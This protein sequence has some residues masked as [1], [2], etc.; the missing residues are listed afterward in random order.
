MATSIKRLIQSEQQHMLLLFLPL[1]DN[2]AD[3]VQHALTTLKQATAPVNDIRASTGVHFSMFYHLP[4]GK[5]AGLPIP[6]FQ[7]MDDRG[8]FVVQAIYDADF[9]P[10]IK[11]FV[12]NDFIAGL[13]DAIIGELNEDGIVEPTD[14]TSA[15]R[16]IEKGGVKNSPAAFN[17]LLMR[18]NFSDPTIPA[19]TKPKMGQKF[20]LNYT[21][22]GLTIGKI[23]ANYPDAQVLWPSKP[24]DI[25]FDPSDQ[26]SEC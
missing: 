10:Y 26:P 23:L 12:D 4:K 13:L 24:E 14:P 20:I 15:A 3:K 9:E 25:E 5:S 8:L 18:Y 19:A 16:I 21:F 6:S 2:S 1:K 17:C 11:S 22:P 7:A